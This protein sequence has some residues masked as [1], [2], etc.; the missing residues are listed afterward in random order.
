M[1]E[2]SFHAYFLEIIEDF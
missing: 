1:G 2:F